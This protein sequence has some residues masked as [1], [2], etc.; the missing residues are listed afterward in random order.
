MN[1]NPDINDELSPRRLPNGLTP[2]G[3]RVLHIPVREDVFRRAKAQALLQAVR[4]PEFVARLLADAGPIPDQ[5]GP[6]HQAK[7]GQAD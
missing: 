5:Q 3:C 4:F 1:D 6:E 2:P 7:P